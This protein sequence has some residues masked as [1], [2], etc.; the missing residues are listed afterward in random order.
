MRLTKE[1][2]PQQDNKLAVSISAEAFNLK[3]RSRAERVLY[4][5]SVD[6]ASGGFVLSYPAD[7]MHVFV[8][9]GIDLCLSAKA[10]KPVAL[11]GDM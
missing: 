11:C 1:S 9:F 5:Q 3:C 6:E 8:L 4:D 7:F 10:V 2:L